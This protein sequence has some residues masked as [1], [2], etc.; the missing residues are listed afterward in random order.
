MLGTER[1][2]KLGL[3]D[4][5]GQKQLLATRRTPGQAAPPTMA[6]LCECQQ[7]CARC[8]SC[9]PWQDESLP[10][11]GGLQSGTSL[12]DCPVHVCT[13]KKREPFLARFRAIPTMA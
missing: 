4:N 8:P 7:T 3:I 9:K 10:F 2:R 5:K 11:L 13:A 12:N 6:S 1:N